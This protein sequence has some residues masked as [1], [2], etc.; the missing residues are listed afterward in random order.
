MQH[1]SGSSILSLRLLS[2]VTGLVFFFGLVVIVFLS[3]IYHGQVME[4][5]IEELFYLAEHN[6]ENHHDNLTVPVP[7]GFGVAAVVDGAAS[8]WSGDA[9]V[10]E[11]VRAM[12]PQQWDSGLVTQIGKALAAS[13]GVEDGPA[14]FRINSADLVHDHLHGRLGGI[15]EI[16]AIFP[17]NF[18][19][20]SMNMFYLGGIGILLLISFGIGLPFAL[21][22]RRQI[23]APLGQLIDDMTSFSRN[24]Y[25]PKKGQNPNEDSS[26]LG[27]AQ[28]ALRL[29]QQETRKELIQRDK[30]ASVGGA[31]AKINHDMRNV[32]ASSMLLS[33]T[34]TASED[35]DV[36]EAAP[37]M[38]SSIERAVMLCNQTLEYLKPQAPLNP[39]S[40]RMDSMLAE[41]QKIIGI[42]VEYSGPAS[43][44]LDEKQFF[45][46][47]S[48]LAGNAHN[49]G[50]SK[51]T[52]TARPAGKHV[53]IDVADDGPGI[54][55]AIRRKLFTPFQG[56][57]RG[58]TGLGLSIAR[59]IAV[60][61]GGDMRL[62]STGDKGS[63]FRIQLP[64]MVL[65]DKAG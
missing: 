17:A 31:V 21:V 8:N 41:V 29:L 9:R 18:M 63:V 60:S 59:D 26:I 44:W 24:L 58:R 5:H 7:A 65:K 33:D 23:V 62:N 40:T 14:Y 4:A 34:L 46:L 30:L 15:E 3:G 64:A 36:R 20:E 28:Y 22:V 49:A 19:T 27:E 16:L 2:A 25:T 53:L 39:S 55:S 6:L 13:L 51:V 12:E 43:M 32:L 10:V 11:A 52:V 38:I 57:A 50:A 42:S 48:N 1:R 37:L 35:E 47:M 54:S 56:G 45:R 61:H